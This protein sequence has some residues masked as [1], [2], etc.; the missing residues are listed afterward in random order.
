MNTATACFNTTMR[1]D[2]NVSAKK[3]AEMYQRKKN[4]SV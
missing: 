1:N 3:M 2:R 4:R